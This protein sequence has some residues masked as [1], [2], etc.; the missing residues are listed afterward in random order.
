MERYFL[1]G[2]PFCICYHSVVILATI[3]EQKRHCQHAN[4]ISSS[5]VD[6]QKSL[7]YFQH[8]KKRKHSRRNRKFD[9][10]RRTTFRRCWKHHQHLMVRAAANWFVYVL[11]LARTW[12]VCF[13]WICGFVAIIP[14]QRYCGKYIKEALHEEYEKQGRTC[15]ANER[16]FK[17]NKSIETVRLGKEFR[18]T[19]FESKNERTTSLET[20][21]VS[22]CFYLFHHELHSVYGK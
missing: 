7:S 5:L 19:S 17:W 15:Q 20:H 8:S 12:T 3:H 22:A 18:G 10:C 14:D 9:V 13:R 2:S 1:R 16:N 21:S 4:P 11:P 6:L